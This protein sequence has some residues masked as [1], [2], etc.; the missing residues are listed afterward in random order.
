GKGYVVEQNCTHHARQYFTQHDDADDGEQNGAD[1]V[2]VEALECREQ[3]A[4]DT[5]RAHDSHHGG[6]AQVGVELVGGK[7]H[8]PCEHLRHDCKDNHVGEGRSACANRFHLF[9]RDL[10]D[11]F[12][13]QLAD[14]TD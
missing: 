1:K 12:G 8:E 2:V 6:V 5:A 10:F 7:A 9:E 4:A 11:G 3:R 14:E 13:E